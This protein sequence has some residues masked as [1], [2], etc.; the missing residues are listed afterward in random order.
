MEQVDINFIN[1]SDTVLSGCNAQKELWENK[2]PITAA[3]TAIIGNRTEI[4]GL[5]LDQK[6][7]TTKGA[8]ATLNDE[9]ENMVYLAMGII[10]RLRPYAMVTNNKELLSKV[11]YSPSEIIQRKKADC[12]NI[13]KVVLQAGIEYLPNATDYE[14]TQ[15][16]L[17]TFESS[18]NG[19]SLLSG[20]RD[21]IIGTRKTA[22]DQIP[23]LVGRI[24]K[25]LEI[26]DDLIP[27]MIADE[28]FV[29]TYQNNRRIFDR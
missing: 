8:T 25:Q 26:L 20:N 18:I 3:I 23:V 13:C 21:A 22:T 24:R 11:D 2:V 27:A 12:L 16:M 5:A 9:F 6:S 1:M 19:A 29:R 28:K 14:L 15:E 4:A 7:L 10:Q 17:D